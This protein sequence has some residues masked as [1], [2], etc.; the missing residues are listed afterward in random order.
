MNS[1]VEEALIVIEL[2]T[3]EERE[4]LLQILIK[5]VKDRRERD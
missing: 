3:I 1:K 2:L 5:K 4:E